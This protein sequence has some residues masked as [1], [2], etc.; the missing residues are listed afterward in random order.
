[1]GGGCLIEF[2]YMPPSVVFLVRF[3]SLL[4]LAFG[5]AAGS[6]VFCRTDAF[7]ETGGFSEEL[8]AAEEIDLSRKLTAWGKAH[9]LTFVILRDQPHISSG[10]KAVLYSF[11]ELFFGVILK[12]ALSPRKTLTSRESLFHL[13]DRRR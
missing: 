5:W 8:Y 11:K 10:R 1:V 7:R 9:G 2:D 12:G 13:Y 3:W 6:F 4:S